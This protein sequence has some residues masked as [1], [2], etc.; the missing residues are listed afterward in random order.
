MN[1]TRLINGL[2]SV[3]VLSLFMVFTTSCNDD[4]DQPPQTT[5]QNIVEVASA[6]SSFSTLT[7]AVQ[8]AGLDETLSGPGPF[9]VF[10]PTNEAFAKFLTENNLTSNDL[11]ASA[12]L[13][14]ILNYHV[15][16]SEVPASAVSSGRVN[17][18]AS[19][20]FFVSESPEGDF[21]INGNSKIIQTDI[22]ISNGL[23]HALD[24]VITPPTRNIAQI[25]VE[26][27]TSETPEFTHLVAALIRADLVETF[28]GNFD[29]DY[30][31][32]APTDE[33]FEQFF[34][35]E[36]INGI[37][38]VPVETLT[39]VLQYH[40]VPSREFSQDLREGGSLPTLLTGSELSVNLSALTINGSGLVTEALNIHGT[41]GVIHA[42]DSVLSPE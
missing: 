26:A 3:S 33:A 21:W 39:R 24:N 1:F 27:S 2:L 23:I 29:Q 40:V 36:G 17:T 14:S 20:P 41:N 8:T 11:L 37:D 18:A 10:A 5:D 28:S 31:V 22:N 6:E 9:T 30:T 12:D 25:A 38:D 7:T 13:E 34:M 4:N 19:I 15:I 42:I 35:D 16:S 32:F